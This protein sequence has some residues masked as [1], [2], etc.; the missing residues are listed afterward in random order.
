MNHSLSALLA[1]DDVTLITVRFSSTAR[2]YTYKCPF[3][4][5]KGDK[6]L[7]EPSTNHPYGNI[8]TVMETDV[9]VDFNTTQTY[10][11]VYQKVD[12]SLLD[13]LKA[14]EK[15]FTDKLVGFEL[16]TKRQQMRALFGM[17]QTD[18]INLLAPPVSKE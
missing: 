13:N 18:S 2:G 6:V 3:P 15:A 17:E 7:V 12:T 14:N 9:A 8:A 4:V 5:T 11:W 1:S 10:K 16:N